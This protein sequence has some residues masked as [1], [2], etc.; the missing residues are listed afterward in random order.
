MYIDENMAIYS[1]KSLP[2]SVRRHNSKTSTNSGS[3]GSDAPDIKHIENPMYTKNE[4]PDTAPENDDHIYETSLSFPPL[5]PPP[6]ETDDDAN[7]FNPYDTLPESIGPDTYDRLDASSSQIVD[8][9]VYEAINATK[10][11]V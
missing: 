2:D 6:I 11:N 3:S 9:P 7:P 8:D 5:P 4:L 1:D 10:T